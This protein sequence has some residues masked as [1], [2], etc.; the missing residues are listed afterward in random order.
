[1]TKQS[2]AF[3]GGGNMARALIGGLLARG[4]APQQIRV[5]EPNAD[6]RQQLHKDFSVP[7]FAHNAEAVTGAELWLIAVKPQVMQ[8]VCA[9][10]APQ[11]QQQAPLVISIA[12]GV[13]LASLQQNLQCTR[14]VRCMPNTPALIGLGISVLYADK[15]LATADHAAAEAILAAAGKTTWINDEGLMD[16]V[17]ATSGSGPAYFFLLIE[18]M[19][20]AAQQQGLPADV[21]RTLVLQTALGAATMA[22][23]SDEDASLL[24]QR[25]TSPGG[26][27]QAALECFNAGGFSALVHAAIAA[28][29]QRGKALAQG[30]G[31][32]T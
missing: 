15:N 26:T 18:A 9:Q 23:A 32:A 19:Q 3:I 21:A 7:V 30:S 14:V 25:V 24:R 1:M 4:W 8:S 31:A 6:L 13:T 22:A 2:I 17:T 27:T 16:A 29:T 5:A 20:Q 28:A 10:L 12:A 11:A